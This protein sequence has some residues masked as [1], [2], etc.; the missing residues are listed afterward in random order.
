MSHTAIVI[1][2]LAAL[3]VAAGVIAYAFAVS[4]KDARRDLSELKKT[5]DS[6]LRQMLVLQ[7][8]VAR[9]DKIIEAIQGANHDAELQRDKIDQAGPDPA[10]RFNASMDVLRDIT[11]GRSGAGPTS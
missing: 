9:R 8:E 6:Y 10:D 1:L 4:A 5:V 2:I 3:A 7:A 11:G